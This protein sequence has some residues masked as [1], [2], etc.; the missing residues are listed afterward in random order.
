MARAS[1]VAESSFYRLS[2]RRLLALF[3]SVLAISFTTIPARLGS[4]A[5]FLAEAT[6]LVLGAL[7]TLRLA[8][9]SFGP[10]ERRIGWAV[11]TLLGLVA[12]GQLARDKKLYP[13]MP[14]TMYGRAP[15]GDVI[16]YEFHALHRSGARDRF[17]PSN[18]VATLGRARIVRG[19]SRELDAIARLESQGKSASRERALLQST[20]TVL[21]ALHNEKH[22]ADPVVAVDVVQVVLPPPYDVQHAR[23]QTRM[24]LHAEASR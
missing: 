6:T 12:V 13:F 20:L 23:R 16:V 7:L 10:G 19:L 1:G 5:V 21:I 15:K 8:P 3:L 14:Y 18:V 22:G 9:L 2:S 4:A 17:R 24:T 11:V